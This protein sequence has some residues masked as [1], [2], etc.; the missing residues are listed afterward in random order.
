V[1]LKAERAAED[2]KVFTRITFHFTVRGRQLRP[3]VVQRAVRLS[4][5]KYCSA[6]VMLAKTAELTHTV[7]IIEE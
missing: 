4:H 2:P 3:E 1:T 6:S 7:E 5:D